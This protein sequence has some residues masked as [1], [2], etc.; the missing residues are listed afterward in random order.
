PRFGHDFSRLPTHTNGSAPV[1]ANLTIGSSN[2]EFEQAAEMEA[3]QFVSGS[4]TSTGTR[5][6]F[7]SVR[8]HTDARSAE[9]ARA[10]NALAYTVGQDMVFGTGQYSPYTTDGRV[11]LA[12]ELS[13][14]IQQS[15]TPQAIQRKVDNKKKISTITPAIIFN[16]IKKRNPDLAELITTQS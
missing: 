13:H 2:D 14:V 3:Q 11:L 7:S 9:S 8:V 5:C 10:V 1:P 4:A 16:E 12:H 6:D 15:F